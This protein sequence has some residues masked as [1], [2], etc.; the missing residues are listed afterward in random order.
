MKKFFYLAIFDGNKI[1]NTQTLNNNVDDYY[2]KD[3]DA[4]DDEDDDISNIDKHIYRY[5]SRL[6]RK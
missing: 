5:T 4:E 2:N 6:W 3:N 1:G